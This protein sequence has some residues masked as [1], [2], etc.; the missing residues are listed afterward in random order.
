MEQT[1]MVMLEAQHL[2]DETILQKLPNITVDEIP[3]ILQ[4][5]G[6]ENQARFSS[7]I[8]QELADEESNEEEPSIQNQF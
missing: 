1:Q 7:K 6:L 5:K 4:R 8:R 2:D 3:G